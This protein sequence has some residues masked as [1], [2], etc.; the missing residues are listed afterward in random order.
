MPLGVVDFRLSGNDAEPHGPE[1]ASHPPFDR[2]GGCCDEPPPIVMPKA[3]LSRHAEGMPQPLSSAAFLS[4][5]R[6]TSSR[7]KSGTSSSTR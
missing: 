6:R 2:L 1:D 3:C 4:R 7:L 5:T